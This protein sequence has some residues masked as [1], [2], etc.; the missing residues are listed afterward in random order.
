M[1][2]TELTKDPNSV[3]GKIV[4]EVTPEDLQIYSENLLQKALKAKAEEVK[5][6]EEYLTPDQ[7]C[8]V[9]GI[10]KVTLW[11]YDKKGITRPLRIGN[12]KRYR[13]SD[14]EIIMVEFGKK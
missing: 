7:F 1:N 4:L 14:L 2:I 8:E 6:A 11:N 5:P 12:L 10:S 3:K 13:R 9:L